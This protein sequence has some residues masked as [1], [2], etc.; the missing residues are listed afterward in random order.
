MLAVM[1]YSPTQV[2]ASP[3]HEPLSEH[4]RDS[5]PCNW[6]PGMQLYVAVSQNFVPVV[7]TMPLTGDTNCPQSVATKY[8]IDFKISMCTA[9]KNQ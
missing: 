9:Y 2:G 5:W 6:N 7:F 8:I 4:V 3:V 1:D